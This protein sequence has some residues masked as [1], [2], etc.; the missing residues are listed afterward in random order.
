MST[1]RPPPS[2]LTRPPYTDAPP[3]TVSLAALDV[4]DLVQV[5]IDV[6]RGKAAALC[7]A[8]YGT[9]EAGP[10]RSPATLADDLRDVHAYAL[11]G[12]RAAI[13]VK[14]DCERAQLLEGLTTLLF[15]GPGTAL[16]YAFPPAVFIAPALE[17][18][19]AVLRAAWAR[20]ALDLGQPVNTHD[21]ALLAGV[22][23]SRV[24]QCVSAGQLKVT[25]GTGNAPTMVTAKEALRWLAS[26]VENPPVRGRKAAQ[27]PSVQE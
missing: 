2:P 14:D 18:V 3:L 27:H 16:P 4:D 25:L 5:A 9:D 15:A 20:H 10:P 7:L 1:K 12:M 19:A 6:A 23:P 13:R 26:R 17:P 24:R 11:R 22:Y 21:L 8:L